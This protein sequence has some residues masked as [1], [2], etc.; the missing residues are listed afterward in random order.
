[1]GQLRKRI[2]VIVRRVRA[3][4]GA[5]VLADLA[6]TAEHWLKSDTLPGPLRP[7]AERIG[8]AVGGL[9]RTYRP[10]PEDEPP[11]EE[12]LEKVGATPTVTRAH[13][14]AAARSNGRAAHENAKVGKANG[15]GRKKV[16]KPRARATTKAA[17]PK[18]A[19]KSKT[20][21]EPKARV[22]ARR[23]RP[24]KKSGPVAPAPEPGKPQRKTNGKAKPKRPSARRARDDKNRGST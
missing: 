13:E 7:P 9:A 15:Q 24:K 2:G 4:E 23:A 11:P 8:S 19:A 20:A 21:S 6:E 12:H 22:S 14:E 1:M 18:G 10:P 3:G 5:H 17:A 16:S